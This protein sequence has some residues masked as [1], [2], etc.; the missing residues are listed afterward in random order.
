MITH[1]SITDLL[2]LPINRFCNI[3]IALSNVLKKRDG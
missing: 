3:M 1:T 2:E